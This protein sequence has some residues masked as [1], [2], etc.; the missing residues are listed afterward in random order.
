MPERR[1]LCDGAVA[2]A[3]RLHDEQTLLTALYNTTSAF[4]EEL[5]PRERFALYA[6]TVDLAERTGTMG[7]I[8]SILPWHV[9]SWLELGE[10]AGARAAAERAERLLAPYTRPHFR[11][12]PPLMRAVVAAVAGR[13]AEAERLSRE[14]LAISREHELRDGIIMHAFYASN[15]PYITGEESGLGE[16]FPA[17]ESLLR[18]LPRADVFRAMWEAPLGRVESV[19]E[20]V[21]RLKTMPIEDVFGA[22]QLGWPCVRIGLVE[23]AEYF[24][25]LLRKVP[26][27]N[28]FGFAPGG[29][30]CLGPL[31]LLRGQLASMTHRRDEAA[32]CFERAAAFARELESPPFVAHAELGWAEL[33]AAED[34]DAAAAHARLALDAAR[35]V[36]MATIGARARDLIGPAPRPAAPVPQQVSLRR[37]GDVWTLE[38]NGRKVTLL[39]SKGMSYLEMLIRS[40]HRPVH[41][42][43]LSGIGEASDAGPQLDE[44]ARRAYRAR[45][46][47]LR[48]ELEEATAWNDAG[49]VELAQREL[50]LLGAE[51]ARA[52]GLGGR[53][54][55]AG[56]AAERA[57]INVQRRLRAVQRRIAEQ[58][59]ALVRHFELSLK[60]GLFCMYAP[61]WP[62]G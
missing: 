37:D 5:T 10:P 14:S 42:L 18:A 12:R 41:A 50:D 9:V 51:L 24:Y 27:H 25:Q 56:S 54:R 23:H 20:A 59:E 4:P 58:D 28:I 11:W 52:F 53:E 40:P 32:R 3:R 7:K 36:G 34:P 16:L 44:T 45:A 60:T 62:A 55:R 6:E 30:S 26:P 57:R 21:D 13:F 46:E 31:D 35:S 29:F 19:R 48:A 17:I 1:R 8:A 49:R 47:A 38:V 39:H 2:M 15:L 61:T 33:L 43:E 22:Y